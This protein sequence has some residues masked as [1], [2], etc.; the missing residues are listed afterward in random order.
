MVFAIHWHE[1]AMDLHVFP[2]PIPPPTSHTT[3]SLWVFPV[4][5]ARALVSC[6]THCYT[7]GLWPD[8]DRTD[9]TPLPAMHIN[10]GRQNPGW[11]TRWSFYF[12]L[13]NRSREVSEHWIKSEIWRGRVLD[14]KQ[15]DLYWIEP[16]NPSK[17]QAWLDL[18][19]TCW[20]NHFLPLL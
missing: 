11:N 16:Y 2:I 15:K 1:S 9:H 8:K 5:Q 14:D 3:R 17:Q 12:Q 10:E 6:I 4:H 18:A 19:D 13:R 20:L 7:A